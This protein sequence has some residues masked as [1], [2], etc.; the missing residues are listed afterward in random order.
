MLVDMID[1]TIEILENEP[2]YRAFHL[3]SQSIVVKDYL[4][5]KPQNK[6]R[7]AKLVNAGRLLIGPWYILP[8]EFQVGG[9]NLIRNLLLGHKTCNEIGRIS[10]IGYSPFSWGQ[11]SQLPQI[12]S[13]FGINLIM[14]YR[15]INSLDSPKAEFLWEGADGTRMIS[16][17]FSTMPRYNFYFYIYR[18]VVHNE[19]FYDVAYDWQRGGTPFHFADMKMVDEDYFII[20]PVDEYFEKN[21]EPQ[22]KSIIENQVKDFTTQHVIWM[23]GHDSSGPNVKTVRIIEDIKKH[24]PNLEILHSTLEEYANLLYQ[25]LAGKKLKLVKGERRSAQF[26][27]RSGNLYGYTTSA[28]MFLKQKNFEAEKLLQFYAEPF[29]SISS[30]LGRDCHDKYINT[31]WELIIQNSAHDSIGGC[32]LD[33]IHNDMMNRYKHSI[34]ISKGVFER[35]IKYIVKNINTNTISNHDNTKNIF[36]T[37]F[38]P[39][40]SE[41]TDIIDVNIDIPKNLDLGSFYIVDSDNKKLNHEI[42]DRIP[43]QPVIEQMIDRPMYFDMIR[44]K[45]QLELKNVPSFGY[46]TLQIIPTKISDNSNKKLG[47]ITGGNFVIENEN[48]SVKVNQNGTFNFTN[49]QLNFTQKNLGYF[50]DEGEAGH[51]W[52]NSPLAP[53]IDTLKSRPRIKFIINS[54]LE[55]KISVAHRLKLPVNLQKRKKNKTKYVLVTLEMILSLKKLSKRV[56]LKIIFDNKAESHRLRIM[57]PTFRDAISSFGEGQFDVVERSVERINSKDWIEQPMYDFPM[58]NFVDVTNGKYGTAVLVN[59]L[60]EYEVK[61]DKQKTLAITLIR[62]FEYIIA[63]S[64]V[65]DYSFQKGAQCLGKNEFELSYY[66][67]EGTWENGNVF[68]EAINFNNE[69]RAVQHGATNG[70]LP[71]KLSFVNITTKNIQFSSLKLAENGEDNCLILRVFNPTSKTQLGIIKFSKDIQ[72]IE[73]VTLEEKLKSRTELKDCNSFSVK[74]SRKK[75]QTF[76]IY[77]KESI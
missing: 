42:I 55:A 17:R 50:Y 64:S 66:L 48:V 15:G 61:N 41:R 34:E 49:K 7:F 52:V 44:Y 5:I 19:G 2:K 60:K 62:S 51:A 4:E 27:K 16:S 32:S 8:E 13:E 77:F 31:A 39:N 12:Y 30:I 56:D 1:K 59:G 65:Q 22:V 24:F 23:E 45:A 25:S 70:K 74:L 43:V 72:K 68:Q 38:N 18:P 40:L 75:I 14:F 71:A 54:S 76:K 29:N 11:I 33:E 57:F 37:V 10:K 28:R 36:L 3:D 73:E 63:P 58:H 46:Q 21:I 20:N 9:E 69:I 47:R 67:H 53:F 35:S 26:D 6:E